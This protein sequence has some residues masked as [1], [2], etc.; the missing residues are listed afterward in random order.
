MINFINFIRSEALRIENKNNEN[1]NI[2][3]KFKSKITKFN[4]SKYTERKNSSNIILNNNNENA[5]NN[6]KNIFSSLNL[7]DNIIN[8]N[9]IRWHN[10]SCRYYS[11]LTIFCF[12]FFDYLKNK[13]NLFNKDLN[14]LI[15][16][17][18]KVNFKFNNDII[19]NIWKYMINN[20]IDLNL[21]KENKELLEI[22]DDG[23]HKNGYVNHL[24]SI[25]KKNEYFWIIYE[26]KH[27]FINCFT[28]INNKIFNDI[29]LKINIDFLNFNTLKSL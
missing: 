4:T 20:N 10:Y 5:S 17:I 18:E 2:N 29:F 16:I 14:Y 21:S 1:I 19:D 15:N 3:I 9:W 8:I 11:F 12:I 6:Y 24:F 13:K 25:F 7:K 26:E 22:I 23:Y 28:N 27:Y